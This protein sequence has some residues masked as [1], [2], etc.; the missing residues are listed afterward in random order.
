MTVDEIMEQIR[1]GGGLDHWCEG[2]P[3]KVT[4]PGHCE[5]GVPVEPDDE[6]CPCSFE[7][8]DGDCIMSAEYKEVAAK[9]A[10]LA[11]LT[12]VKRRTCDD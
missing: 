12:S 11:E 7:I 3:E 4:F 9:A 5:G 2:C 6:D 10:E 1:D 8:G